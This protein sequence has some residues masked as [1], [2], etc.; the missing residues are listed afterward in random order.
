MWYLGVVG[1]TQGRRITSSSLGSA[2]LARATRDPATYEEQTGEQRDTVVRVNKGSRDSR[3]WVK[4]RQ[5][6]RAQNEERNSTQTHSIYKTQMCQEKV[7]V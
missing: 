6:G 1:Q 2:R 4:P 7:K 3:S 5:S